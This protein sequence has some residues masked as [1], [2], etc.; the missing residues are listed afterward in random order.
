[1]KTPY[2]KLLTLAAMVAFLAAS[3][4][5]AQNL[6]N[7]TTGQIVNAGTIRF[8]ETDGQFLNAN[9]TYTS[10]YSASSGTIEFTANNTSTAYFAGTAPLGAADGSRIEGWVVYAGNSAGTQNVQGRY[11]SNLYMSGSDTKDFG[12]ET[13][14]VD[15]V[16]DVA[17]GSGDRDY[18]ASTFYYDGDT[19]EDQTI[20]P[21]SGAS[22]GNNLYYNLYFSNGGTKTLATGATCNAENEINLDGNAIVM[23]RGTM[24]A[25]SNATVNT[26]SGSGY[27]AINGGEFRT[28]DGAGTLAGNVYIYS[29]GLYITDGSGEQTFSGTLEVGED[30]SSTASSGSF[31]LDQGDATVSGTLD[32]ANAN[33]MLTVGASRTLT[34]QGTFTNGEAYAGG[35][36]ANMGFDKNSTVIYS[37]GSSSQLVATKEAHPYGHLEV[38]GGN[39]PE[40]D[41]YVKGTL[42]VDNNDLDMTG[43]PYTLTMLSWDQGIT[44][45]NDIE[46][47]GKLARRLG[48]SPY[49]GN[50]YTASSKMKYN[51]NATYASVDQNVGSISELGLEIHPSTQHTG[52]W[53]ATTDVQRQGFLSYTETAG[54]WTATLQI[55]YTDSEDPFTTD[56]DKNSIRFREVTGAG[57]SE[58]IS[59][60]VSGGLTHHIAYDVGSSFA[61]ASLEGITSENNGSPTIELAKV[62]NGGQ[63]FLRGGPTW[64]I[65]INDGRWSNPG[66]WDEGTQPGPNDLCL[67]RHTVHVGYVR[68]IDNYT[69]KEDDFLSTNFS[70]DESELAAFV[71]IYSGTV[72]STTYHGA[73]MFGSG[74]GANDLAT[75]HFGLNSG[76]SVSS[77]VAPYSGGPTTINSGDVFISALDGAQSNM[78]DLTQR[79]DASASTQVN[80]GLLIF[81]QSEF[82]IPSLL[83]NNGLI[84]NHGTLIIGE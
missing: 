22:G 37:S 7:T 6:N 32:L 54:D 38:L 47:V 73:L 62:A 81:S 51:N 42:T 36:R 63:F 14:N 59:T 56:Q 71:W 58:K 80:G 77:V 23:V 27:L 57:T 61:W 19:G 46:L 84:N 55:G 48:T 65:T 11:Y 76:A 17:S 69:G 15:H 10:A 64:F 68:A 25:V 13:V 82:T 26:S 43:G 16:Y 70:T 72:G 5:F 8:K 74:T 75:P 31:T 12:S 41:V 29:D 9:T 44:Y 52:D 45:G 18:N 21:E 35:T 28:N 33:G 1:M 67:V 4:A 49:S 39:T 66:T 79:N 34:I 30:P 50:A 2:K 60:G 40:N 20:Y 3:G 53:N 24:Q 78:P 83:T